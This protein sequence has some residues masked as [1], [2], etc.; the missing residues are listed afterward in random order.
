MDGTQEQEVSRS[1]VPATIKLQP[2]RDSAEA[3]SGEKTCA[4]CEYC[5]EKGQPGMHC[6][7]DPPTV[8]WNFDEHKAETAYPGIDGGT[9]GKFE[10]IKEK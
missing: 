4:D 2:K 9:C 3:V 6:R 7:I 1:P 10:S 8:Y 5:R